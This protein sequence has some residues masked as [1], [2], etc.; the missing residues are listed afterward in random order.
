MILGLGLAGIEEHGSVRTSRMRQ[1]E[2]I[3]ELRG[4]EM[5]F[6]RNIQQ[7]ELKGKMGFRKENCLARR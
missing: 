3:R 5:S 6:V 7:L 1:K 4:K 2:I